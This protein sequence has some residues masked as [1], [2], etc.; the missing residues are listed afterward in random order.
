MLTIVP[1]VTLPRAAN[2]T[3]VQFPQPLYL[4]SLSPIQLILWA[5]NFSIIVNSSLLLTPSPPTLPTGQHP[6]L[7]LCSDMQAILSKYEEEG[8]HKA[9]LLLAQLLIAIALFSPQLRLPMCRDWL[10]NSHG[11]P[12]SWTHH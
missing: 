8:Q 4:E 6:S 5:P 9:P 1:A 7:P 2:L 12:Y 10:R 11:S 3:G